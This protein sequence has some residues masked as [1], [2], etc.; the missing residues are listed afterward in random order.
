MEILDNDRWCDCCQYGGLVV[1]EVGEVIGELAAGAG[2][3]V[4]SSCPFAAPFECPLLAGD[5]VG[6]DSI[7]LR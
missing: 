2:A 3:F 6:A 4:S 1:L 7:H 5:I